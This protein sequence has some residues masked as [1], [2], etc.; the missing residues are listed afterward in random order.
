MVAEV[1]I[2]YRTPDLVLE[3]GTTRLPPIG[4]LVDHAAMLRVVGK[5]AD[6]VHADLRVPLAPPLDLHPPDPS[7]L[8]APIEIEVARFEPHPPGARARY[9]GETLWERVA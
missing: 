8:C 7:K 6:Q 4:G 3:D 2:I 1:Q 9:T 5:V